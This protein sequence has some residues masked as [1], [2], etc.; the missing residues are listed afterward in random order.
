M[1]GDHDRA[2]DGWLAAQ[3]AGHLLQLRRWAQLKE[4]FGWRSRLVTLADGRGGIAAGAS[5]LLR[6]MA[7]LTLAYAPR[8]PVVDW[9]DAGQV[10]ELLAQMLA[11]SRAEGAAVLKLEPNLADTPAHRSLLAGYGLRPSPQAIQP[12]STIIVDISLPPDAILAQMKSKWRY[13][14]RLAERKEVRVRAMTRGDLPAF[15]ALMAAT[16]QRD[17]F[18][19]HSAAYYD[20]AFDLLAPEH[21]VYLLAEYAGAPLAAIV[22]ALAGDTAIYLWGASADRE[23]SRM[24]NH[25]LQWAGM[26]W[27]KARGA[28]RYDLW[29]IPDPVGQ[30]A[31]GLANGDGS[32]VPAADLPLDVEAFPSAGLWGVY[33]FKQGFGGD[34]V[35]FTGAWDMPV[36]ALGYRFYSLGLGAYGWL[37]ARRAA[38]TAPAPGAE[39]A[40]VTA[41]A[42]WRSLLASLPAPH[43]LQSWEWGE[44][45]RQTEWRSTRYALRAPAGAAAFQL[46]WRQPLPYAPARVAYVPKGP[47]LDWT[48]LDLVEATLAAIEQEARRLGCIFV[49]IDPD[50]REDVT[51]G[52]LVL[53]LLEQRGWRCSPEQ[54]QF[55]NT[56]W[57]DL[58]AGEEALLAGMKSK[59]RYNVRLAEKRGVTVRQGTEADLP[60]FYDL[61]AETGQRDGFLI[62]PYDYYR[63]TWA[64]MLAAQT[65]GANPAGGALLLAEHPDEAAPLAGIFLFRYGA[66]AWYFYGASSERRRRDMPNYLL[67]WEALRWSLAQ[68]C[69]V[70][71]WWGAPV[72]LD[73]PADG[74]HG[75]WQFKQ[76]FGAEF[77]PHIG[78]WD[79]VVSP[80]GYRLY[81][82]AMPRVLAWMRG[83]GQG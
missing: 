25:A 81:M 26:Q 24:P 20:A 3:P 36:D 73:D 61:Y 9:Q 7:G 64:T 18:A 51:A 58:A 50:V 45:K 75:V 67:Q 29:G 28:A 11:A 59:H 41:A 46:L 63:T 5:L 32:G 31:Q 15:H 76:G 4:Q 39:L 65:D 35:R 55:K 8:G 6:R 23:R 82:E 19:V 83:H 60:A 16:G 21:A 66:R 56:A 43:V 49:K 22:V 78:A 69:T 62:R 70:Y 52:R 2:W 44:I 37:K 10:R 47:V 80:A 17:Q 68:G 77:Q 53:H 33:R 12:P 54:I 1:Y 34:V 48:N 13:N 72:D 40:P 74:L 27:A 30:V 57:S 79:Y 42:A 38:R 71:D 14:V